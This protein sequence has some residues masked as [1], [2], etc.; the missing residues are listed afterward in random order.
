MALLFGP[1]SF[2]IG[3]RVREFL[4]SR[5]LV[6]RSSFSDALGALSGEGMWEGVGARLA[7]GT[8]AGPCKV[9]TGHHSGRRPFPFDLKMLC[10]IQCV[11]W[12]GSGC[13]VTVC[14]VGQLPRAAHDGMRCTTGCYNHRSTGRFCGDLPFWRSRVESLEGL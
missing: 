5:S 3:G 10:T 11:F 2:S 1:L 14:T 12:S 9:G 8:G 7:G 13:L 6:A 4:V